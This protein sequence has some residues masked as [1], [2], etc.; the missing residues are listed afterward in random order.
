METKS[1]TVLSC[2]SDDEVN[3]A[4]EKFFAEGG[5]IMKIQNHS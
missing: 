1:R 5:K 4:M 3:S 2:A